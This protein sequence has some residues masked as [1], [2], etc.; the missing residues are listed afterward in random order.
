MPYQVSQLVAD[1]RPPVSAA[2]EEPLQVALDR[3]L[4]HGFSQLP[5][6]KGTG[7]NK[8]FYFVTHQSILNALQNFGSRINGSGLRVD[9]ALVAIPRPYSAAADIFEL[10]GGMRDMNAAIIVDDDRNLMH[11]ITSYDTSQYF[12]QWAEDIMQVR[13]V[14]HSLRRIINLAFRS[15]DGE[16]DKAARQSAVDEVSSPNRALRRKFE[17]AIKCYLSELQKKPLTFQPELTNLAFLQLLSGHQP[18][19]PKERHE[20]ETVT[21][22]PEKQ[23]SHAGHLVSASLDLQGRFE[24]AVAYYVSRFVSGA[25]VI[26]DSAVEEA[27]KIIHNRG[28]RPQEFSELALGDYIQMFFK[29]SCWGKSKNIIKLGEEEVRHML[30]GVR[31]TR[32]DLAHFREEQITA[33]KRSQL[34]HCAEWLNSREK[35]IVAALENQG[36]LT[37]AD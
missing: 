7:Q 28:E 34:R 33:Q 6:V 17:G 32:N 24:R 15:Q 21:A 20:E 5:V 3:M 1:L 19:L 22:E 31:E 18:A 14:E 30:D 10:L 37:A 4:Q 13:D 9:D 2:P 12:R 26:D 25:V 8:Q 29:D 27:F 35:L 16:I 36:T 23:E 11:V